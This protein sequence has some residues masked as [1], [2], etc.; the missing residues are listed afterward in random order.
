MSGFAEPA[1]G[2][3]EEATAY[4]FLD[5]LS[6]VRVAGDETDGRCSV[7]EMHL[8]EGHAP[9]MHRHEQADETIHVLEGAVTAHTAADTHAVTAGGSIVLPRG[10]KHSLVAE[11]QSVILTS[12][13]PGGFDEFVAAAG[14]PA[15]VETVPDSPP[16]EE[17]IGRVNAVAADHGIELLGPPPV[18]R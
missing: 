16:S 17:A 4:R 9:P 10:E 5:T 2:Q 15:D 14:E 11:E 1:V 7:V 18:G 6:Y 13:A 12:T 3:R 8:R